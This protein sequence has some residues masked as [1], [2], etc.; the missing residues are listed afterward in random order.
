MSP[1]H[2]K[3]IRSFLFLVQ[4]LSSGMYAL[5]SDFSIGVQDQTEIPHQ[6]YRGTVGQGGKGLVHLPPYL[7]ALLHNDLL[8]LLI[9]VRHRL[10]I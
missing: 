1:Q 5:S 6:Y 10:L 2:L 9:V 3:N 7:F 8:L 4:V